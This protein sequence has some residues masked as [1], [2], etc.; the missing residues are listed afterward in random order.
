MTTSNLE[1]IA[2]ESQTDDFIE[3]STTHREVIETVISSLDRDNTAMVNHTEESYPWK[4]QYGSVEVFVQLTG[5]S[6]ED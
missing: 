6:D 5:E 4:F 3:E 2:S 1:T